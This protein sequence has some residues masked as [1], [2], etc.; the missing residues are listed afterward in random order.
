MLGDKPR[1][2]I[3]IVEASYGDSYEHSE[4]V[5]GIWEDENIA[6]YE[7]ERYENSVKQKIEQLRKMEVC[8]DSNDLEAVSDEE[9]NLWQKIRNDLYYY[10][11]YN[12]CSIREYEI[13]RRL[14]DI[15]DA[16]NK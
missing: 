14:V 4:I 15:E 5:V 7:K 12:S 9:F 1:M 8:I 11:E 6:K 13:N 2:K 10:E 3:Y 16:C